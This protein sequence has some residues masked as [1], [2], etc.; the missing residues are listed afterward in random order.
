MDVERFL[1]EYP[2]LG[3]EIMRL[4]RELN[5]IIICKEDSYNTLKAQNITG[6]P[7][8]ATPEENQSIVER[9]VICL[10]DRYQERTNYY[11]N[12]INDLIE[13]QRMFE[14]IWADMQLLT[15]IER[16][17]IELRC[18]QETTWSMIGQLIHYSR[19]GA[20]SIYHKAIEKI[21]SRM[22]SIAS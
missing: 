7:R 6:M 14:A 18:F 1:R 20:E 19:Q 3:E 15:T 17:V 9:A 2:S 22:E 13:T 16:R 10:L 12:R 5:N 4:N 11:T 21:H 8:N